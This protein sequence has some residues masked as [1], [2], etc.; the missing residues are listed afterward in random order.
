M[1]CLASMVVLLSVLF[2]YAAYSQ[3]PGDMLWNVL[4]GGANDESFSAVRGTPDGGFILCGFTETFGPV[5][6]VKSLW[7]VKTDGTGTEEWS[8]VYGE[9]FSYGDE[10]NDLCLASTGGYVVA[11][12]TYSYAATEKD[13]WMLKLDSD[14]IIE[15]TNQSTSPTYAAGYAVIE[16]SDGDYVMAGYSYDE[17]S[18]PR[19]LLVKVAPNGATI[20]ERLLGGAGTETAY[21][22]AQTSDGGYILTGYTTTIGAGGVDIM[23]MKTDADGNSEWMQ[24]FGTVDDDRGHAVCQLDDGGFI[25]AGGSG[26]F[27]GDRDAWLV[28]TDSSGNHLWTRSYGGTSGM[29]DQAND[30]QL[31]A[32]GGFILTGFMKSGS[33][34]S[35]AWIAK[36]DEDGVIEWEEL[37]GNPTR[38]DSGQAVIEQDDGN[39]MMVGQSWVSG[40]AF[41]QYQAFM[42]NIEG[43]QSVAGTVSAGLTCSPASGTVP[44]IT[45]ITASITN[46]YTGQLRRLAAKIHLTLGG[47]S[48]IAGW[49]AGFTNVSPGGDYISA[50]NQNL[51]ALGSLIGDNIFQLVAEDVT[52]APYNQPP[53]PPAGDNATASCTVAAYAP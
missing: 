2:P 31:A 52:P 13:A 43:G 5:N 51:P 27:G 37:F 9:G 26:S 29:W 11:G 41:G 33:S 4:H 25:V 20:W 24:A 22:L 17:L 6:D 32:D 12:E 47:G 49:R 18:R 19:A 7:V 38:T 8:Q 21:S 16:N 53:Y 35:D 46:N 34:S 15:W 23:L 50:W 45:Q 39:Y 14:G 28:R 3:A 40:G 42:M 30:V 44:F 1:R 10:A 36:T 48:Y